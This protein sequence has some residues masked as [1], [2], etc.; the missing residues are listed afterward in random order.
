MKTTIFFLL[1]GLAAIAFA[2][3]AAPVL[4]AIRGE[5]RRNH[6]GVTLRQL[7]ALFVLG[8]QFALSMPSA[9]RRR[10]AW[11]DER[12]VANEIQGSVHT[13]TITKYL[14]TATSTRHLIYC[15]DTSVANGTRIKL[16]TTAVRPMFAVP[17]EVSST[18]LA[19]QNPSPV[20]AIILGTTNETVRM[21]ANAAGIKPG[22]PVFAVA[23][24][25]VDLQANLTT[26]TWYM[27]GI[28]AARV[29]AAQGDL[30][31][32]ASCLPTVSVTV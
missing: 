23:N 18:D 2:L 14:A 29:S 1:L 26:G 12:L 22:D 32:V 24:G 19:L 5:G 30:L 25:M 13:N 16:A 28:V 6:N 31:E 10:L 27:V 9:L 4:R 3:L 20:T 17:D 15:Q 21:V 7:A 8:V 11:P